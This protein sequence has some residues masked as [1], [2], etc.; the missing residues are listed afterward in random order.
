M[1]TVN[2]TRLGRASEK[3]K[4]SISSVKLDF[5]DVPT[6]DDY[7][8]FRLPHNCLVRRVTVVV[9]A[10]SQGG[11]TALIGFE[12]GAVLF[13]NANLATLGVVSSAVDIDTGTG[14]T[15]IFTPSTILTSGVFQVIVEYV[16]Y[17]LNNSEYTNFVDE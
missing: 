11:A 17:T 6:T 16:E 1:A 4:Y 7:Q 15:I 12:D 8:V 2:L 5:S 9:K 10:T 13:P 3:K 14:Q